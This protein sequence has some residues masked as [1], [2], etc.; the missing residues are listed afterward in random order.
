MPCF[1]KYCPI[2][3][4]ELRR[5]WDI[6]KIMELKECTIMELKDLI[7]CV[8]IWELQKQ[9]TLYFNEFLYWIQQSTSFSIWV[10]LKLPWKTFEDSIEVRFLKGI[11]YYS[12]HEVFRISTNGCF[13]LKN[14]EYQFKIKAALINLSSVDK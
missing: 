10:S 4:K 12:L 6:R 5:A 9:P 11:S 3:N 8:I 2:N 1:E 13:F 7:D 14:I